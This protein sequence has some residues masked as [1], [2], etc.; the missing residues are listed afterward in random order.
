MPRVGQHYLPVEPTHVDP[1]GEEMSN[2]LPLILMLVV[3]M[4]ANQRVRA[5]KEKLPEQDRKEATVDMTA[6][7]MRLGEKVGFPECKRAK[8]PV[9]WLPG[10]PI[11]YLDYY[12]SGSSAIASISG[13]SVKDRCF[14]RTDVA[15]T[16]PR[17]PLG[18]T[19]VNIFFPNND[20]PRIVIPI[21]SIMGRVIDGK[22]ESISIGTCGID[23]QDEAL[24][25][26]TEKYGRPQ[27]LKDENKQ[28]EFGA[29]YTSH[30][31]AWTFLSVNQVS[32]DVSADLIVSFRGTTE[33]LDEGR[34]DIMTQKG[35]DFAV[36][37]IDQETPV[38]P[39]L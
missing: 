30:K 34:I 31:A 15:T 14:V 6:Y 38:G 25:V 28:N 3:A 27:T 9:R 5:Q 23:C 32:T 8:K 24:A 16:N 37:Q 2:K 4:G 20:R 12:E 33:R 36:S 19:I 35:L 13:L 29:V 1:K 17:D 39:K 21:K 26:L 11:I 10:L 18:A 7:G 22:L